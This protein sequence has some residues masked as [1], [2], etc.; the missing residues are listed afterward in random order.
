MITVEQL[1][2]N[3]KKFLETNSK[4]KIF[5]KE[6][7]N[8]LGD[9]FYTAPATTTIDMYG[10]YPGGLLN[11]SLKACKYAIKINELLPENMREEVPT[12]LK[13]VFLSQIG[14]VFLFCPNQNEW[15]RKTLGKMYEFC[16]D[17]V[18]LRV[19]ERSVHYATKN[20]V[21]LNEEEFQTVL[22][23]DKESDDKMVKYHS[24]N[25]SNVIK[26]GFELAILEEKNGQKRN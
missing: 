17:L 18:S 26:L 15:Q 21:E 11:T 6:L 24:S 14:K 8:F 23:T 12:I 2:S 9:D 3:K 10:C 19:G 16:N 22:N 5:T 7:E 13:C 1:E 25:L 20:G 4:Y